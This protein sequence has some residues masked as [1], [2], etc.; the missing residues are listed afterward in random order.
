[1]EAK[2]EIYNEIIIDTDADR[3][4]AD[5]STEHYINSVAEQMGL[6]RT[7]RLIIKACP[8]NFC[9]VPTP[10]RE[11]TKRVFRDKGK[12]DGFS[13]PVLKESYKQFVV[14]EPVL[15]EAPK[16]DISSLAQ[17][18]LQLPEKR[19]WPYSPLQLCTEIPYSSKQLLW[20]R[21]MLTSED[22]KSM[23]F[24][25]DIFR[26]VLASLYRVPI[27]SSLLAA[28]LIFWNIEGHTLL[29][30]QGEM[31]YPLLVMYDSMGLP[32]SGH[33]YEEFIQTFS[34]VSGMVKALHSIYAELWLLH[35]KDNNLVT[36][37]EWVDHFLGNNIIVLLTY[38]TSTSILLNLC[39]SLLF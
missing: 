3:I 17:E 15:N 20:A 16:V 1:M 5:D 6:K 29:T 8:L 25:A 13:Q 7:G 22:D 32:I 28:F 35:A 36:M 33:I 39:I 18:F 19:W 14:L 27:N 34:A 31:G 4:P 30:A 37:Q 23:L 9:E 21:M 26:G 24:R 2:D 10:P 12:Q 38:L 11:L